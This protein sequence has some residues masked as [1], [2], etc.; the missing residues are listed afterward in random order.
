M[1]TIEYAQSLALKA[2]LFRGF[3]DPSRLAILEALRAGPLAVSQIV[4]ATGLS[5][6]NASNHLACLL[7]C[8]LV[9]R[10]QQGRFNVYSLADRRVEALLR[11]ADRI[12]TDVARGVYVCPRYGGRGD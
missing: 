7:D 5:Q 12:L 6:S 4:D 8:E 2:K 1:L 9:R 3:A 10:E 11:S